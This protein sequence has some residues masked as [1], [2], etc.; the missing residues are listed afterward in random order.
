MPVDLLL[1]TSN[2]PQPTDPTVEE[3]ADAW[4]NEPGADPRGEYFRCN[5]ENGIYTFQD[6]A[7][8]E[9]LH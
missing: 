6:H 8:D 3:I 5:R 2:D 9:L 7:I 4:K 1:A